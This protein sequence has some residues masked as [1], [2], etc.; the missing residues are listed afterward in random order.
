MA[1]E[2]NADKLRRSPFISREL[3]LKCKGLATSQGKMIGQWVAEAMQFKY[4]KEIQKIKDGK[5]GGKS[6]E[7]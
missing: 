3:W 6:H 2:T 7:K 1:L 5:F 4:D